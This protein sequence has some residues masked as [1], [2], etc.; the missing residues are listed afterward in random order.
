MPTEDRITDKPRGHRI[1]TDQIAMRL[2]ASAISGLNDEAVLAL[3]TRG[4]FGGIIFRIEWFILR[5]ALGKI[6]PAKYTGFTSL[7]TEKIEWNSQNISTSTV[8]PVGDILFGSFKI[9]DFHVKQTTRSESDF[10]GCHRFSVHR[11]LHGNSRLDIESSSV[12]DESGRDSRQVQDEVEIRLEHFRCNPQTNIDSWAE[13]ITWF[14][15]WYARLLF[16]DGIRSVLRR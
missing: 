8:M 2:P 6:N 12:T 16:A 3:F 5:I 9:V 10:G 4:F 13:Y 1:A 15:Y 14:H 7:P 11:N